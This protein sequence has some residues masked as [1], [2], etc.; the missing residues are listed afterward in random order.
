M[1]FWVP[2]FKDIKVLQCI[3]RRAT[4]LRKGLEDASCEEQLRTL[5]L[6]SPGKRRLRGD[7][8]LST[9]S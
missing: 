7:L 1:Q 2:G 6:S 4:K 3:Q 5:S 9:A 8:Q